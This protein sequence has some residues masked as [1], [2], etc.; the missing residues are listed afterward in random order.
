[1]ELWHSFSIA[2][3]MVGSCL[4]NSVK[5]SSIQDV[6]MKGIQNKIIYIYIY[7][8][9]YISETNCHTRIRFMSS[10]RNTLKVLFSCPAYAHAP[11]GDLRRAQ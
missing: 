5:V 8:Y 4:L 6:R 10:E 9:I 2:N 11:A 1:V 7:I 3:F